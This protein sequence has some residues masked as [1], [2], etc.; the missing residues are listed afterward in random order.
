MRYK[1]KLSIEK[2]NNSRERAKQNNL[3]LLMRN[4]H[5]VAA[6]VNV[7]VTG[8]FSASVTFAVYTTVFNGVS[9]SIVAEAVRR[10][11]I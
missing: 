1:Y 10:I 6:Q 7:M 3:P 4:G 11:T 5:G 8:S 9:A 2:V